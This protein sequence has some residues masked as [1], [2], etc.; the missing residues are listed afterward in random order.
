MTLVQLK[1]TSQG[2]SKIFFAPLPHRQNRPA[3]KKSDRR[4]SYRTY[5][6][7]LYIVGAFCSATYKVAAMGQQTA[8]CL[9]ILP[10]CP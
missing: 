6:Q 3:E 10:R 8:V 2:L 9:G 1:L 4:Q 7:P 5:A